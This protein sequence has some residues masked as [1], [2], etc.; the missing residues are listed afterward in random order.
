MHPKWRDT[1]EPI[2]NHPG[3]GLMGALLQNSH[4]LIFGPGRHPPRYE[5]C[6]G[7]GCDVAALFP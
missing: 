4:V 5:V 2:Q 6:A 7:T 1:H 3:G